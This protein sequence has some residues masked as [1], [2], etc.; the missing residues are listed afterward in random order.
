[1]PIDRFSEFTANTLTVWLEQC[2]D[3]GVELSF[4]IGTKT[5]GGTCRLVIL[6]AAS[7][8]PVELIESLL[9]TALEHVKSRRLSEIKVTKR[10]DQ[11][12]KC[13]NA[14]SGGV[15]RP[16]TDRRAHLGHSRPITRRRSDNGK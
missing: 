8:L 7:N 3:L 13:P 11:D 2:L 4:A 14:D 1:M 12:A 9:A 6:S 5:E 10:N 15:A 16:D